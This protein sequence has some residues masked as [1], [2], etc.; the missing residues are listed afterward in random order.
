MTK[1]KQHD[2]DFTGKLGPL[3]RSEE[4]PEWPMYSFS[5]VA[6]EFWNGFANGLLDRGLTEDEVKDEL[7]SK[8]VRWL[9]DQH[10]DNLESLGRRM[11][12]TYELCVTDEQ[13]VIKK[14]LIK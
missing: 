2:E 1:S 8:G 11:A 7:Q 4:V 12:R 6:Y 9:L 3:Y 5:R 14:R 13:Q 10:G